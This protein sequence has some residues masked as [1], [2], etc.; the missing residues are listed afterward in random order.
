M[1]GVN[2]SKIDDSLFARA[3][4]DKKKNVDTMFDA[5]TATTVTS[6]ERKALQTS[7]DAALMANI[8]KEN[9]LES[10]L[11]ALFTLSKADKP[12]SMKF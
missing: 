3:T 8:K 11:K 9:M 6:P 10:Y 12:H 4:A 5:S 1:A 7:V 2:V